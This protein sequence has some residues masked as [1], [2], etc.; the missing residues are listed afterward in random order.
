[1]TFAARA[2]APLA[3]LD[4][5]INALSDAEARL[6][7]W[8]WWPVGPPPRHRPYGSAEHA[9][10]LGWLVASFA[11]SEVVVATLPEHL[12]SRGAALQVERAAAVAGGVAT[13]VMIAGA[14]DRRAQRL[15]RRPWLRPAR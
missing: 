9:V 12:R 10:G 1:M 4:R 3:A 6:F 14:W 5:P 15:R 11:L 7:P 13:W 2:T 8:T